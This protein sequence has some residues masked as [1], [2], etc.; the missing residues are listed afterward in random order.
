M[1]LHRARWTDLEY[2]IERDAR[3]G[4]TS[5]LIVALADGSTVCPCCADLVK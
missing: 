5:P 2:A 1:N 3:A 4:K